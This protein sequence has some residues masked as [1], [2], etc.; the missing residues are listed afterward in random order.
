MDECLVV[1]RHSIVLVQ[2]DKMLQMLQDTDIDDK[3]IRI[4][5]ILHWLQR[6]GVRLDNQVS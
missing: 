5:A 4:I 2:H 6:A 3:D 1:D